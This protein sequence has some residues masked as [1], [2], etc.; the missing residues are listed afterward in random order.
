MGREV[1]T[2]RTYRVLGVMSGTSMDGIDLALCTFREEAG[3]WGHEV[4]LARTVPFSGSLEEQLEAAMDGKALD[5]ARLHTHLGCAIGM[6]CADMLREHPAEL[7]ASHGHTIFH[8]PAEGLTFQAGSGAHI[9]ALSGVPVVCDFRTLDMALGGQGAPLVP[10]GERALFPGH[11]AFLNLGGIS[12]LSVHRSEGVVGF[13]IC[14]C[15]QLLDGLAKEAGARYDPDGRIAEAGHVNKELLARLNALPFYARSGP[16]SLGR[17]WYVETLRPLLEG[18]GLPLSD[19][20]ATAVRH[21]AEQILRSAK[22]ARANEVLVTGGGAHNT[23]LIKHLRSD[24]EVRI[25]VPAK[26]LVDMKEAVIF[27]FLGLMRFLGRTNTLASVTGAARDT[28]SGALY[29][30]Y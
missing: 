16:R 8:R 25:E 10:F 18:T 13:D 14:P 20:M 26:E 4:L 23:A 12:N 28:V 2:G 7:V 9:A 27:A 22:G 21:I 6:A 30:P 24:P 29:L 3:I 19:R 17:E 5:L 11:R 15:N 1:D